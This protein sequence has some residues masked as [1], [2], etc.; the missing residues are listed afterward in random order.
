MLAI[1][2]HTS[3]IIFSKMLLQKAFL[4]LKLF[5]RKIHLGPLCFMVCM[6][7]SDMY[8]TLGKQCYPVQCSSV[9]LSTLYYMNY[10]HL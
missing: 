8:S 2:M 1:Q 7:H 5:L 3:N 4:H 6:F 9:V 10:Y